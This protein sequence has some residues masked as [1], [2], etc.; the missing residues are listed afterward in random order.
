MIH[1]ES[2]YINI[3]LSPNATYLV[4]RYIEL[5]YSDKMFP[6]KRLL[7]IVSRH[8]KNFLRYTTIER[9]EQTI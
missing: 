6:L 7:G 9:K 1:K 4:L 5:Y 2:A 3:L 8:V